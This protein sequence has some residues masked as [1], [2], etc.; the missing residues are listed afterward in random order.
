MN[1]FYLDDDP[2]QCAK[3]HVDKH[4]VK[5]I[6]EYCQ[7][8]STAHRGLDGQMYYGKTKNNRNIKRWSLPDHR[9]DVLFKASHVNHPSNVWTRTSLSNYI[10]LFKLYMACIAEYKYRY[11][12]V[13]GSS[14]PSVYLQRPPKNIPDIGLTEMPQAMPEY[15]KVPNDPISG[16]R[17]YYINEKA[18]F[19]NWKNRE[20]PLWF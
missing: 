18:Y 4:I 5:M 3:W 9:E 11:G 1:I 6:T 7:L 2:I 8:L 15:C 16:Y 17:N 14:K 19:A 12:K 20:K 13:H 10:M